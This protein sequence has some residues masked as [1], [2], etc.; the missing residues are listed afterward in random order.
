[1]RL[2][3]NSFIEFLCPT[4][5]GGGVTHTTLEGRLARV[6]DRCSKCFR[7]DHMSQDCTYKIICVHCDTYKQHHRAICPKCPSLQSNTIV[8]STLSYSA[9]NEGAV[10]LQTAQAT[11]SNTLDSKSVKSSLFFYSGSTKSF[12]KT[13]TANHL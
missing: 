8:K 4:P 11:I 13:S 10:L 9:H 3:S 6:T 12:I 2:T 1:M 5:P 7:Q